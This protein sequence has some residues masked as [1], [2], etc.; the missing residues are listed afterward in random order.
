[1]A[2]HLVKNVELF[3]DHT[4]KLASHRICHTQ[5]IRFHNMAHN[6][7]VELR[8]S[9]SETNFLLLVRFLNLDK[10]CTS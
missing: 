5:G 2:H 10:I 7:P 8:Y 3:K 4:I 6:A 1:M 9:G